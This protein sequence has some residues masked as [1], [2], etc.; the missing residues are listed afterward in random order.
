MTYFD[1]VYPY[2]GRAAH[3]PGNC[4][5]APRILVTLRCSREARSLVSRFAARKLVNVLSQRTR[6]PSEDG[7]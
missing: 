2:F 4:L 5:R 7:S 6:L 1:H 3:G